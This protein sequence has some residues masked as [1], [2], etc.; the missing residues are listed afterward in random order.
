MSSNETWG[1]E[2]GPTR[3]TYIADPTLALRGARARV[4]RA[5]EAI[6]DGEHDLAAAILADLEN[7]LAAGEPA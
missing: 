1:R 4:V 5:L 7:D 2:N 3:N 6:E